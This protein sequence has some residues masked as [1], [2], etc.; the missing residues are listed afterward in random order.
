MKLVGFEP[1]TSDHHLVARH[2]YLIEVRKIFAA[3]GLVAIVSVTS[4]YESCVSTVRQKEY[5]PYSSSIFCVLRVCPESTAATWAP[6][7]IPFDK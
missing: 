5:G 4:K 6:Q 2:Y 1:T 7:S 3:P